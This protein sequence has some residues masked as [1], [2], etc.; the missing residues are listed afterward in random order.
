MQCGQ[1]NEIFTRPTL[2]KTATKCIQIVPAVLNYQGMTRIRISVAAVLAFCWL[3]NEA[4]ADCSLTNTSLT[5]LND[6][7][8]GTYSNFTGGL[9]LNGTNTRPPAHEVAGLDIAASLST[10]TGTNVLLSIGM[11]NTTQEFATK[12]PGAFKPRADVD[13]AKNPRLIIVDG[14]Q[15]GQDATKWTNINAA[16][17]ATVDQRLA[18]AHVTSNDVRV[19]WLKQALAGPLNYGAFPAHARVLQAMLEQI[20]RNAKARYP[21]LAIA[22][23]SSRTRCYT[24]NPTL[25]NPE[26][27]AYEAGWATKWIIENQINGSNN[28][29]P[30][31][32]PWLSWGPYLWT[33]GLRGRSDGLTWYCTDL[34]SDLTH[35]NTNGVTKVANQLLAFFKTD[36]TAT[37]WFLRKTLTPPVVSISSTPSDGVAP[38]TVHF[39]A[40]STNSPV[41]FVWTFDDGDFS[42]GQSPTKIFPAAGNYHVH[43]TVEDAAGNTATTT[44]VINVLAPSIVNSI[45]RSGNDVRIT[46]TTFGGQSY[47]VQTAVG[48]SYSTNYSDVSPSIVAV[49]IGASVTNFVDV[50]GA[51]NSP[52]RFY[53]V[54]LVP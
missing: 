17:W 49:G 29:A 51:T 48:D 45:V 43:L 16:T 50:G 42:Y 26:P 38:L 36:P 18:T 28:L 44:T 46:W 31:V 2:A 8:S 13:P 30:A 54:K 23:V 32:A 5:P 39:S 4:P 37:P 6:L 41:Q 3:A 52:A 10:N 12:G 35:P 21:N 1:R 20:V 33:D 7:G 19:V 25:L 27:F 34:E 9:Y 22:Y 11:S 24:N 53:R 40:S 14:A 15:G 47:I